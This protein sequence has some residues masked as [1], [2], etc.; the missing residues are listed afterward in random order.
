MQL[1]VDKNEPINAFRLAEFIYELCMSHG[2]SAEATAQMVLSQT[3]A[4]KKKGCAF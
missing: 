2:I 3:E 1:C 4:D